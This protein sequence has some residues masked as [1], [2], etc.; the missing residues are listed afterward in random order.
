MEVGD[1]AKKVLS[2]FGMAVN[3]KGEPRIDVF[4]VQ[5]QIEEWTSGREPDIVLSKKGQ[6]QLC[7]GEGGVVDGIWNSSDGTKATAKTRDIA[8]YSVGGGTFDGAGRLTGHRGIDNGYFSGIYSLEKEFRTPLLTQICIELMPPEEL[9]VLSL[10]DE[11]PES[12]ERYRLDI[13]VVDQINQGASSE[14]AEFIRS[15]QKKGFFFDGSDL[16]ELVEA[17]ME[18]IWK[19]IEGFSGMDPS[20]VRREME[21]SLYSMV[22]KWQLSW[23][24]AVS[25]HIQANNGMVDDFALIRDMPENSV[26]PGHYLLYGRTGYPGDP[27]APS[28]DW[29]IRDILHSIDPIEYP[30]GIELEQ[31]PKTFAKDLWWFAEV[32]SGKFLLDERSRYEKE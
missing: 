4:D 31:A 11:G 3:E 28:E 15:Y 5:W 1:L 23:I 25:S 13:Y 32:P 22:P 17:E 27:D 7:Y 8:G 2:N 21:V 10:L 24:S 16:E 9:E 12:W 14:V 29:E 20:E 26:R 19:R 18:W 30:E 6:I